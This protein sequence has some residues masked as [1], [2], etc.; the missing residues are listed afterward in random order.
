MGS[1]VLFETN[2]PASNLW[3]ALSVK[4]TLSY[5]SLSLSLNLLL[6]LL[7][8]LRLLVHRHRTQRHLG[9]KH[10]THYTSIAAMLVE[11]SALYSTFSL[12]F[13]VS[14]VRTSPVQNLFLPVLAEVQVC[15]VLSYAPILTDVIFNTLDDF[16]S[17]DR[18]SCCS[19][20]WLV[21]KHRRY[22]WDWSRFQNAQPIFRRDSRQSSE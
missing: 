9:A 11:S 20:P 12:I 13:I 18:H 14:Y 16:A 10:A 3:T 1:L 22:N 19:W 6:T 17:F 5:F 4:F 15:I 7:I 8:V 21:E 2:L